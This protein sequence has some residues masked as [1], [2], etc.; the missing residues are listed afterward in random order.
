MPY[1]YGYAAGHTQAY[2]SGEAKK[3]PTG[4]A[5]VYSE[6]VAG[7]Y[8]K[9]AANFESAGEATIDSSGGCGI[10]YSSR[11][12]RAPSDALWCQST[13]LVGIRFFSTEGCSGAHQPKFV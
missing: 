9:G 5:G 8:S 13:S 12:T 10:V 1:A 11:A 2:S 3:T 4:A 7:V 6:G